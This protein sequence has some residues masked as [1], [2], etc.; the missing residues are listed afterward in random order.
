MVLDPGGGLDAAADVDAPG[1]GDPDGLR[2]VVGVESP[3]EDQRQIAKVYIGAFLDLTMK[4]EMEYLPLF[5]DWRTGQQWLPETLYISRFED[6]LTRYICD[7]DEDIDLGDL[8]PDKSDDPTLT[9]L[10]YESLG[11]EVD[12]ALEVLTPRE[13]T[14]I[15][16]Y[17]GLDG[18]EKRT[19]EQIGKM[20]GLTRERI[21]QIKEEAL[22]KLRQAPGLDG[23]RDYLN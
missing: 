11:R 8:V 15:K 20:M 5:R 1:A 3:G 14:I 10:H 6:A 18:C 13:S 7:Y 9:G 19:L 12:M 4:D 2:D 21:R 16:H 17:F 23:L 22:G